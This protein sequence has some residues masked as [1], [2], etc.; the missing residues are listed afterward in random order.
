MI[1]LALRSALS[2]RAAEGR[3]VVVDAWPWETP[4]TKSAKA[5][6]GALGVDGKALVVLTRDDEVATKSFRNLPGV[7]VIDRAEL[8]TYD[9]LCN[10]WIVFTQ[11]TLPTE[12]GT[13]QE[14]RP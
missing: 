3:V 10:E 13:K 2:D 11:A 12:L 8:N 4:S 9:V 14:A 5:A 7:Q 1:R 6:L